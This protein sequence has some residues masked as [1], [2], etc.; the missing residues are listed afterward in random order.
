VWLAA[1]ATLLGATV[2]S[3]T[4]FGF[5]LIAG[6]VLFGILEPAEALT[7]VLLLGASLNLLM[8]FGERRPRHIRWAELLVLLAAA[9]PGL[10]T[11]ALIL[12]ALSKPTLQVTVG[13]AVV[14][15]ALFQ[16]R[17]R[18]TSIANP[19]SSV[20][21]WL[22]GVIG[23]V[24]GLLTTTTSTNGPP[25][26]LWFQRRGASPP[27]LRD[28]IAAAFLPLNLLGALTLS[29]VGG[30]RQSFEPG[31]VALLLVF[32]AAGHFVGRRAFERLDPRRFRAIGL[33]LVLL[34][35][36]ASIVAGAKA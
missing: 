27:E 4:G 1:L 11:G 18:L 28:S 6:P 25:L 20:R 24:A 10:I 30:E 14:L 29:L 26:V 32:T 21:S 3:A 7:T 31:T 33:G 15:A 8:L 17:E 34:A 19:G 13:I 2:Q 5:A 9:A 12:H 22:A 16:A 23:I 35:G 36:I